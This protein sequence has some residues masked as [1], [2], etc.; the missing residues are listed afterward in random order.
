MTLMSD[1]LTNRGV[2]RRAG[3]A[4]VSLAAIAA[5]AL[6]SPPGAYA[7]SGTAY[8]AAPDGSDSSDCSSD[9]PCSLARVQ[10]VVQSDTSKSDS[11]VTVQLGGGVYRISEPLTFGPDDGGQNGHVVT[12]QAE[13]GATPEISGSSAVG[14]WSSYDQ[15]KNIYVADIPAGVDSRQLYV[16]G[17]LAPRAAMRVT[18][19]DVSISQAGIQVLNP[20]LGYL[21]D[22]PQQNRIEFE[23]MGDF[24]DR[25]TPV[26]SIQGNTITMSQEA[27]NNNT[28]GYDTVQ[29][30]FLAAPTWYLQNSLAFLNETGEWYIDPDAGKVYYKP[31]AGVDPNSLDV[32][33]PTTQTLVSVS[34][35]YDN[36]VTGLA[37]QGIT[38]SGTSWMGPSHDGY[39]NTQNG[40][41]LN[42]NYASRPADAY[43]S[44]SRG[45]NG[46]EGTRSNWYQ[47]PAA[48]QV[49]AA[50]G[51]SFDR[52]LFTNLGSSALGVGN[53]TNA[54]LSGVGLGASNVSIVGNIFTEVAGHGIAVGGVRPDAHHPSD[55]RM[56]NQD[57]LIQDNTVNRVAVDY[58]DN[59]GILSTYVTRARIVNNEV[60]NVSYDGIDTGYG[61]GANDAGGTQQY[62]NMGYYDW[63]TKYDT[64]TTLKDNY[65]AGNLVHDTKAR[66]ADGGTIY[67]LS[68]SPGTIVEKNYLYNFPGVGL[69]L[70]D[71]TRYTTYRNNVMQGG[72]PF[73]FTNA[74]DAGSNTKDNMVRDNWYSGNGA[75]NPN[76]AAKNNQFINNTKITGN[77]WPQAARDVM[78]AAGV[79]PQYR[80]PL[81]ANLFGLTGCATGSDVSAP[82]STAATSGIQTVFRQSDSVV[83]IAAAGKDIWGAGGQHDDEYGSIYRAGSVAPISSV[84]ARVSS[85]NDSNVWAKTGV[86]VRNALSAPGSSA[87]YAT[88]AV[89]GNNGI[90]FAWDSNGDG[91]LDSSAVANVNTFR[92]IWVKVVRAGSAFSG[93]YS[94]DGVNYDQIGSTVNL[95]N[96]A[97]VQDGGVFSTSHDTAQ[98]AINVFTDVSVTPDLTQD[99]T[100]PTVALVTPAA[101]TIAS[102]LTV[103]MNAADDVGLKRIVANVYRDGQ[104]VK[105]TQTAVT[106]GAT[107][108]SHLA[109]VALPD[110]NYTLKYNAEDLAGN[111]STTETVPF[112]IDSTKPTITVKEGSDFTIATGQTYDKISLKLFDAGKIDRVTVNGVVK[113]LT[114]NQWSDVNLL[115]PGT[116]GATVGENTVVAYDIAGNGET[117]TFTLN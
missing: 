104:L 102:R 52:N 94:Y 73:V 84:S 46:Y 60:A 22:L 23:S 2:K 49:S 20:S 93:W 63:N 77:A 11:D 115:A 107:T 113:D 8:Y 35:T 19:S 1:E 83:G 85:F 91:Y 86:M 68:A 44:C 66:F 54:T 38:F 72:G 71:G 114:D 18:S 59:S 29:Y 48:V 70:D 34:G 25:Y 67:N 5:M 40:A 110:G 32:E 80:T 69:Y 39:A 9:D 27:W 58:K 4:V 116:F 117:L 98:S 33:L 96:A 99:M 74:Y 57:I 42:E 43:T 64:P 17:V 10:Q 21:A 37:F 53:D 89:T 26:Q 106:V 101:G 87:G 41:F 108:G 112:T 97:V 50:N 55:P 36:P 103:Q 30:S 24:T 31:G 75:Q 79:D 76:A 15:A 7:A 62:V 81:N 88:T 95:P 3:I 14:G 65:I 56:I 51:V 100:R 105:S 47:E 16:N 61:W 13:D 45:C 109:D 92:P 78:C 28:W 111:I 6:V 82:F 90:Q 12:W